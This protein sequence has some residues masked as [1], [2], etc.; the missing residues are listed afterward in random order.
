MNGMKLI[1]AM[2]GLPDSMIEE[3][4]HSKKRAAFFRRKWMLAACLCVLL[5]AAIGFQSNLQNVPVSTAPPQENEPMRPMS[6][7]ELRESLFAAYCPEY[8]ELGC[9]FYEAGFYGET[10]YQAIFTS[11]DS[12]IFIN[13]S[14]IGAKGEPS[15]FMH[16]IV[17]VS[18]IEDDEKPQ[19]RRP[20][21]HAE[22][23]TAGCQDYIQVNQL[24][25][26]RFTILFDVIDDEYYV[27]Y[28]VK[29]ASPEWMTRAFESIARCYQ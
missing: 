10:T 25:D 8:A 16:R 19:Y 24:T 26:G 13:A 3:A 28:V 2:N 22:Q 15:Q 29:S 9:K 21:F 11:T 27:C 20:V 4:I 1:E 6:E 17:D 5:F 12:V 7:Q 18:L 23:L 14:P